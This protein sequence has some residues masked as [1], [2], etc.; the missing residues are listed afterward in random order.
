M[1][2]KDSKNK[3]LT[4]VDRKAG[5]AMLLMMV[6][7]GALPHGS[8]QKVAHFLGVSSWLTVARLWRNTLARMEKY[9]EANWM[10]DE[11]LL[12]NDL[13]LTMACFPDEVFKPEKKGVVGRKKVHDRD[14]LKEQTKDVCNNKRKTHRSHASQLA[15][16]NDGVAPCHMTLFRLLKTEKIFRRT[17]SSL[18]PTLTPSNEYWRFQFVLGKIDVDTVTLSN[19]I[20]N[21]DWKCRAL[22]DTVHVDEKWFFLCEDG[23][24]YTLADDEPE[25][26]QH[27]KHKKHIAKV[28]FLV[29]QARPQRDPNR[30]CTWDGKL[31]IWPVGH[32]EAA[33][34][35][36]VIRPKGTLEWK[37][38]GIDGETY[39]QMLTE[40]VVPSIIA[41]WPRADWNKPDFT[42]TTQHDGAPGHKAKFF[43]ERWEAE[44]DGLMQEQLLPEG[45]TQLELQLSNP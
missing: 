42:I 3:E 25:P 40:K 31:G 44:I 30:N 9:L 38:K 22:C 17:R 27:V 15:E 18:K 21:S 28:M 10:I 1:P 35:S 37:S 16:L 39:L 13:N 36:S 7:N 8:Y 23:V 6:D 26:Q 12:L 20:R 14:V 19:C 45:K 33:K 4:M 32:W 29:A 43:Q 11:M 2:K 5:F 24:S 34:R 41:G